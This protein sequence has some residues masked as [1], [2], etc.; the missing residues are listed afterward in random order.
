MQN[1]VLKRT[2]LL[3]NSLI[4][5]LL[6]IIL[7]SFLLIV[8]IIGCFVPVIPGPIIAYFAL[9][10]LKLSTTSAI[11]TTW[12]WVF[13]ILAVSVSIIDNVIPVYTTKRFGGSRAGTIGSLVGLVVGLLFF[14]PVGFLF[15]PLLGAFA[16]ELYVH[17]S[18]MK[19]AA[20]AALG[21]L[22]GVL[23]GSLLKLALVLWMAWVFY[24]AL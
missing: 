9:L 13:G 14:P 22:L 23:A 10:V 21:A 6:L 7:G 15:G 3:L 16:G 24:T 5:D 4:M 11:G 20:S 1:K 17:Q 12:L 2:I 19:A 8:G 18:D